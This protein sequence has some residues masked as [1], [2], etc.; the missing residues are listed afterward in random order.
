MA[1]ERCASPVRAPRLSV[2]LRTLWHRPDTN[3]YDETGVNFL[4]DQSKTTRL[5]ANS[6]GRALSTAAHGARIMP[7]QDLPPRRVL[8]SS[9][10][11][12]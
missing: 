8:P 5:Y 11:N 10:P 3:E 4:R 6:S 9:N 7:F 1:I 12:D 2:E